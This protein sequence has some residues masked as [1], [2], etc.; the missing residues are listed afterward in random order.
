VSVPDPDFPLLHAIYHYLFFFWNVS[1]FWKIYSSLPPLALQSACSV[2]IAVTGATALLQNR[3]QDSGKVQPD[4][5]DAL[6][7]KQQIAALEKRVSQLEQ[8][9]AAPSGWFSGWR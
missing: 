6:E 3:S 4:A 5:A 1:L 2:V 9:K 7:Q 8:A